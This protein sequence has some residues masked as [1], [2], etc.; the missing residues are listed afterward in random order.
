MT[1]KDVAKHSG[2]AVGTVSRVLNDH[3]DVSEEARSR[4]LTVVDELGFKPNNNA[5]HLKQRE[6]SGFSIIVKGAHNLLFASIV[7]EMQSRIKDEGR[8]V[9]V[10]YLD[11]NDDEVNQAVQV[12]REQKP[13]GMLFLGGNRDNFSQNFKKITCPCV[14]VTNRA[15]TLGFPNLSSVFTDDVEGA[16][17][18]MGML[19]DAG[20]CRVGI[21]GG[22]NYQVDSKLDYNTSQ[23]R[24]IGC[25]QAF[26]QRGLDFQPEHQL[27]VSRYSMEGGYEA[28]GILLDQF[29]NMTAIFAMSDV[30]A[31]G[32]L[33]AI[34]DRGLQ[35]PEDISLMG[36]DGIEQADFCVPRLS[37]IQQNVEQ[38][39]RRGV[40]ILLNQTDDRQSKDGQTVH[41]I[42]P[43]QIIHGESIRVI[44]EKI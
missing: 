35:V 30:M 7:E 17:Q 8:S 33:R 16:A 21:I 14:L 28:A 10:H 1:I 11:E 38:L 26:I 12:Y 9:T 36:Y 43:F 13:L 24:F 19:L 34:R 39:A 37:T 29:P 41:E 2:Y 6:G 40:D 20:H 3:P 27:I 31:I 25:R 23:Q 32:A 22:E 15:D 44:V 4:I 18:A 5:R 42:I